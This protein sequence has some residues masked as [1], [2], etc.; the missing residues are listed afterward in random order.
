MF[1]GECVVLWV[2]VGSLCGACVWWVSVWWCVLWVCV[3]SVCGEWVWLNDGTETWN[4]KAK[5]RNSGHEGISWRREYLCRKKV[6]NS[7]KRYE[8][9]IKGTKLEWK[10]QNS[11]SRC[12]IVK[13]IYENTKR[14]I[15]SQFREI[16]RNTFFVFSYFL[17]LR[18]DQNSTKQWPVS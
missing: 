16:T 11:K 9:R 10:V 6:W 8:I 2:C 15:V 18:N 1:C 17:V 13:K 7:N 14:S 3:V 5:S 12:K 4:T